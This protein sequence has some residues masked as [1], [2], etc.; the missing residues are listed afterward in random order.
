MASVDE[1]IPKAPSGPRLRARDALIV[2]GVALV[3]LVLF[4]GS[5]MRDSGEEMQPGIERTVVLAVGRPVGW[6]ADR[7]PLAD[8]ADGALGWLSPD[9]ELDDAGGF[10][11]TRAAGRR[12]GVPPVDPG[13]FDPAAVGGKARR[14]SRLRTLLVTGDSLAQPLDVVLAR[15]LSGRGV[16][17]KREPHLGTGVSK[18]GFVDWGKL[19]STQ[20][21]RRHPDAVVVFIGANEGFPMPVAG[22]RE[23]EC[24]GPAWAAEYAFRVRRMM[25]NYRR[26]GSARVYYLQL[27]LPRDRERRRIALAVNAAIEVAAVPYRSQVRVID[28]P[29]TFTPGGRYRAALELDGHRRIVREPDGIHLN[30]AGAEVAADLVLPVVRRD[31]ERP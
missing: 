4:K 27:P 31:F 8:A 19:S 16:E 5:S 17:V 12:S 23:V 1:S 24:C 11:S 10:D 25:D 28:L 26:R 18:S 29:R 22:R 21:R 9:D 2:I 14:L 6:I 20:A 15:R 3:L 7:L 13:S 30:E